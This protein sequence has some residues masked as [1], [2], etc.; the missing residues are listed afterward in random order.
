M[1]RLGAIVPPVSPRGPRPSEHPTVHDADPAPHFVALFEMLDA[2]V[3]ANDY[4]NPSLSGL[5]AGCALAARAAGVPAEA[6]V[7][8]LRQRIHE[9]RLS[10]VGDWYRGIL[11]ERLVSRAI[12]A[13][14]SDA[15]AGEE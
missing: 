7:I 4:A 6:M 1:L 10:G 5:A 2:V 14:F 11:I 8:H 12:L 13:Y 15:A 9:L 3:D